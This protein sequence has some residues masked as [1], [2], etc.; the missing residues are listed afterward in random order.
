MTAVSTDTVRD[1]Y[2]ETVMKAKRNRLDGTDEM[3]DII[4]KSL[5]YEISD[6]FQLGGRD[7]I[8]AAG[9]KNSLARTYN[10]YSVPINTKIDDLVKLINDL[11]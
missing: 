4:T 1:R 9:E 3:I 8:F 5:H 7:L 11:E 2:I 10:K 6:T